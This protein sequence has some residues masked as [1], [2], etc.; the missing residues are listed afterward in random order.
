M[1]GQAVQALQGVFD[2]MIESDK[3]VT[4]DIVAV[5][6]RIIKTKLTDATAAKKDG[7]AELRKFLRL[8][9]R[10]RLKPT[11]QGGNIFLQVLTVKE[12]KLRKVMVEVRTAIAV[13]KA[14]KKL[15][16]EHEN[17]FDEH[18]ALGN[19]AAKGF[20]GTGFTFGDDEP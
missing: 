17:H 7:D 2:M 5:A 15:L 11:A 10:V 3:I 1:A 8:A 18:L 20:A 16:D 13:W 14:A 4:V 6:H 19:G 12:V 9:N